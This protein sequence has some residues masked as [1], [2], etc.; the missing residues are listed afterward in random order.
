MEN[1]SMEVKILGKVIGEASSWDLIEDGITAY[2]NFIPNT[3][4]VK[5]FNELSER[6]D[7]S[8]DYNLM[9]D[10]NEGIVQ[11]TRCEED[12]QDILI[13]CKPDWSVFNG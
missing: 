7:G 9:I 8:K 11:I 2:Y 1:E 5:F 4:G 13:T 6:L 10:F 3:L 12:L